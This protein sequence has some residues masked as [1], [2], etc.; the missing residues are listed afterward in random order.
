MY[1]LENIYNVAYAVDG[2]WTRVQM[3]MI[4]FN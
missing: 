1:Y 3:D 2:I 4:F